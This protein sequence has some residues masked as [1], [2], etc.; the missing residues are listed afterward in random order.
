MRA[1][2]RGTLSELVDH[3][4]RA[5]AANLNAAATQRSLAPTVESLEAWGGSVTMLREAAIE[6]I[7]A[8]PV[9]AE[10]QYLLEFEVPRRSRRI[11]AVIL[12]G[13]VIFVLE[14]K[15]GASRFDRAALWQTEQYALD[16][17]DF[18][19]GSSRHCIVP[20]LIASEA[21]PRPLA[22]PIPN[23]RQA[24]EVQTISPAG[25]SSLVLAWWRAGRIPG[26]AQIDGAEWEMAPYLPTPNI[27]E[28][29]RILYE[30]HDVSDISLSGAQ[31]LEAT[32]EGVLDL[33]RTCREQN[34][35]GIAFITGA[36]G[37]GKTLAGLQVV[38]S[39]EMFREAQASGVFLS[40][41]MPLV[42]VITA[43][44]AQSA[45]ARG[46]TRREADREVRTF[47]QH[48]Y[49]F[50]NE[51]AEESDSL[52]PENVVLFDEAQRAWDAKRVTSWTRGASTRSE[53]QILLDVM[54]RVPDWAVL[55]AMVGSGQEINQGEAGLGEWGRALR[56]WHPDWLVRASPAVL[57]GAVAPP[58]GR[59]FDEM[60]PAVQVTRDDRLHLRMNVRSPRAERLNLWVDAVLNLDVE[61]ARDAFPD[62]HEFPMALTR[63]LDQAKDALRRLSDEEQRMGLVASADARRLRAWGIDPPRLRQE[64]DWANWFLKPRGDVRSSNQLEVAATN[65]DCQGLEIDWA[66]VCWGNDLIPE[67]RL[68]G[69]RWKVRR[70]IGSRWT[71][72]NEERARFIINGYRV[73]LTR[74][75]RGQ[76][77]WIPRP[78][79]SDPTLP[80]EDF[81]RVA[82]LLE[83]CGVPSLD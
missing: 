66:A 47:I 46:Q 20:V 35:R 22:E 25:L 55:I 31:N 78:D 2:H 10:W 42:E 64:K 77:I 67:A 26:A 71:R 58:G 18:H 68:S 79:G 76:V 53:P 8:E 27:I 43:A 29:A 48:A 63:S 45:A 73:I 81:D 83:A 59:L 15:V 61:A 7:A 49:L 5:I 51:H 4:T 13:N 60:P 9:A 80:P 1:W 19:A 14:W 32:V 41:N 12:A 33:I 50:R 11:D 36:P 70:F 40:G 3:D 28:A 54:N 24:Q 57:P 16:L 74:A 37:S 44:I 6:L 56:E 34:R 72:A 30:T 65:F 82:A 39:A 52:P 23:E 62:P 38:H 21:P 75:R 17:R 69:D